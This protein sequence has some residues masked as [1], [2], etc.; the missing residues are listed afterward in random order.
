MC[1]VIFAIFIYIFLQNILLLMFILTSRFNHFFLHVGFWG[2]FI[3]SKHSRLGE[4]YYVLYMIGFHPRVLLTPWF[5]IF[6][7]WKTAH[8]GVFPP[9]CACLIPIF[10]VLLKILAGLILLWCFDFWLQGSWA[11]VCYFLNVVLRFFALAFV[12]ITKTFL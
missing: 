11:A 7:L 5:S 1:Q 6:M 8:C 10:F 12:I 3:N 4:W 2:C 9:L